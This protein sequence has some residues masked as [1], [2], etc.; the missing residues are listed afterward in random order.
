MLEGLAERD[1]QHIRVVE[2]RRNFGQ[3]AALSA[4][5]DEAAGAVIVSMDGDLQHAPEDIPLLLKKI[6]EGFDIASGVTAGMMLGYL[7]GAYTTSIGL[8]L[9]IVFAI[10]GSIHSPFSKGSHR[11][12][13]DGAKLV[14]TAQDILEE[15]GMATAAAGVA[16]LVIRPSLS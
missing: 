16:T 3:T 5:F 14:E 9:V 8:G 2:L 15:L 1:P 10:P 13:K 7:L 11:L 12:I 6:D 4:G